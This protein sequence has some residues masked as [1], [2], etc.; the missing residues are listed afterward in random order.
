[1]IILTVEVDAL[2]KVL[3]F[4]AHVITIKNQNQIKKEEFIV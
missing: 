2:I 4:N 3:E 1:M